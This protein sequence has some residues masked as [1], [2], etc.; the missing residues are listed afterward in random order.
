MSVGSIGYDKAELGLDA[1][2]ISL[3]HI[4]VADRRFRL[5]P[6]P[7]NVSFSSLKAI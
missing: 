4:E 7:E 3:A 2:G 1:N 6:T 5:A